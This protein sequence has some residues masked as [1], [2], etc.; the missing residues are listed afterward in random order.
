M[1]KIY[2]AG[3]MRGI[4]DW[5]FPAFD[6]AVARWRAAGWQA[7]SPASMDRALGYDQ[8]SSVNGAHLRH[9]M[10][11]DVAALF[12]ADAIALL[13]GWRR[14][15]G[16]TVELAMAQFLDLEVYCA[17]TM[18]R[19]EPGKLPWENQSVIG[20]WDE[21]WRNIHQRSSDAYQD[22]ERKHGFQDASGGAAPG[23]DPDLCV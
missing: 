15:A 21:A 10:L 18:R 9:V 23:H 19:V 13:P 11:A 3:P 12:V 1:R 4:A 16:A 8:D 22:A 2:I 14:S 20:E 5:N 17:E 7:F 6:A